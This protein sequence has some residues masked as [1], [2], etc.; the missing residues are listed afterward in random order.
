[1][2]GLVLVPVLALV[3]VIIDVQLAE[4]GAG[5]ERVAAAHKV[6]AHFESGLLSLVLLSHHPSYPG[7]A[8][9]PSGE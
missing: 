3:Q 2:G 8:R 6:G 7:C 4:I 5:D 1:M 9:R